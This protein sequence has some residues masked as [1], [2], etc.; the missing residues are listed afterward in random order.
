M[1]DPLIPNYVG[2][3]VKPSFV[4]WGADPSQWHRPCPWQTRC[5][6]IHA[7]FRCL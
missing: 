5:E 3:D 6:G 4:P 1:G 2:I 7:D